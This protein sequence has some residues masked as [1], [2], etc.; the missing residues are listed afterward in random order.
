METLDYSFTQADLSIYFIITYKVNFT[1]W[2]KLILTI[3]NNLYYRKG[4]RTSLSKA[5]DS[6][7]TREM[8][9]YKTGSC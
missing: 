6:P 4:L 1:I 2:N 9:S 3:T 8:I 5:G 7:V